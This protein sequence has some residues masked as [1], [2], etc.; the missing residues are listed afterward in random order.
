MNSKNLVL[1]L[2]LVITIIFITKLIEVPTV[3][4]VLVFQSF[5]MIFFY[6]ETVLV[7]IRQVGNAVPPLLA[8][9]LQKLFIELL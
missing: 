2:M 9:K 3:R 1:R 8:Q 6:L 4:N 5:P 7:N